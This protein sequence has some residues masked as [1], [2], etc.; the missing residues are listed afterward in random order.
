VSFNDYPLGDIEGQ[1]GM[2]SGGSAAGTLPIGGVAPQGGSE[3]KAGAMS[4]GGDTATATAPSLI[5]NFEDDDAAIPAIDGRIGT[6]Y[7]GNDAKGTQTPAGQAPPTMPDPARPGSPRALHTFGMGF[8]EW[9]ALIG[10]SLREGGEY[11]VSRYQGIRLWVRLGSPAASRSMR[12]NLPALG[13]NGV[14]DLPCMPCDDHFGADI[15]LSTEWQQVSVLFKDLKQHGWGNPKLAKPE[16]S[17][18]S[19]LQFGFEKDK[20]FDVWID[21]IELF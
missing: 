9:G 16:L 8:T 12:L 21:D 10:T 7:T 18:V 15:A 14:A 5:D 19:S 1:A 20:T 4:E 13:T 17:R 2:G 6:W 3:P 11:D